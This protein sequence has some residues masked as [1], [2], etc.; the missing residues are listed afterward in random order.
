MIFGLETKLMAIESLLLI[1][2]GRFLTYKVFI[3]H[4]YTSLRALVTYEDSSDGLTPLTL[5]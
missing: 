3:S 5:A 2:R 1:P 4:S